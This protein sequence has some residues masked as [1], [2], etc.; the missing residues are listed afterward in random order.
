MHMSYLI[1]KKEDMSL[2]DIIIHE[3]E[4]HTQFVRHK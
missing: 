3:D 2:V 4:I 1:S